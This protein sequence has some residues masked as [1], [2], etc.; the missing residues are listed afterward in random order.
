MGQH[1]SSHGELSPQDAS[2]KMPPPQ[3]N[4]LVLQGPREA[5][6]YRCD[7]SPRFSRVVWLV[8]VPRCVCCH[9]FFAMFFPING[10]KT[11]VCCQKLDVSE[12]Q[13]LSGNRYMLL[14]SCQSNPPKRRDSHS[15]PDSN[16]S[17]YIWASRYLFRVI[18]GGPNQNMFLGIAVAPCGCAW[19]HKITWKLEEQSL[20]PSL[21]K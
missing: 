16:F 6:S 1:E 14:G 17:W 11:V 13:D 15:L 2:L 9:A 20:S 18:M 7:G 4:S 3:C 10:F 8:S 19:A 5:L 12:A 21:C